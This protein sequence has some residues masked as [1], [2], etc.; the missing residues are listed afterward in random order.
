MK[1]FIVKV[2]TKTYHSIVV[3]AEDEFEAANLVEEK[4]ELSNAE[5]VSVEQVGF[6]E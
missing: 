3:M 4:I 5:V 1:K 2:S 6:K